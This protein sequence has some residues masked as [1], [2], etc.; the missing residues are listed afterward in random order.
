MLLQNDIFTLMPQVTFM[1][2]FKGKKLTA[3]PV[4]LSEAVEITHGLLYREDAA[5]E[6]HA[7][8]TLIGECMRQV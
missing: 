8:I 6:V 3:K 4:Q 5:E 7:F 1:H 2:L